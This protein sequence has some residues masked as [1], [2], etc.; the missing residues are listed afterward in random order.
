LEDGGVGFNGDGNWLYSYGG[1]QGGFRV[2]G[3]VFVGF[4]FE[5]GGIGFTGSVGSFVWVG[6]LGWYSFSSG[7]L[8]SV[9]HQS[10]VTSLVSV[11]SG[12]V[13]DGLFG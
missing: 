4:V 9:V 3:D 12:T 2:G 8:E 11:R 10:S 5:D 6:S 13:D 1:D 7:E